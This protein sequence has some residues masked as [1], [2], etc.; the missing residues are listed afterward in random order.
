M[1]TKVNTLKS[2][3]TLPKY[4]ATAGTS[5]KL[6][7][8][9]NGTKYMNA[10]RTYD[11]IICG[12]NCQCSRKQKTA[13]EKTV[14]GYD[15]VK[16]LSSGKGGFGAV[17]L[18]RNR[19][20]EEVVAIK[21]VPFMSNGQSIYH[22]VANEVDLVM[23]ISHPNIA[24][25]HDF[26]VLNKR[27]NLYIVMEYARHGSLRRL[28]NERIKKNMFFKQSVVLKIIRDVAYGM[29]YL[30]SKQVLH[31]DLKPENILV[32]DDGCMKICDF[33][34]A[35][36]MNESKTRVLGTLSYVAPELFDDML[37]DER[38][39]IW[40]L[41]II[42][43]ELCTLY[44]PFKPFATDKELIGKI[45]AGL[46]KSLNC[47]LSGYSYNMQELLEFMLQTKPDNRQTLSSILSHALFGKVKSEL[48]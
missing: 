15:Y 32:G 43:Y 2:G 39:E 38:S 11:T 29:Q 36:F 44:H 4:T 48:K 30:N 37:P 3:S 42:F 22:E 20:T 28:L 16:Y 5:Q 17:H 7:F 18:Y 33:G 1:S 23:N 21:E 9:V 19:N 26:F 25:Y 24:T 41:G 47:R 8:S 27:F 6:K 46:F 34:T 14:P 40:S 10:T 35:H 13:T 31:C 45:K 12:V